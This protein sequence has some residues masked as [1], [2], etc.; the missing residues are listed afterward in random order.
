MVSLN[1]VTEPEPEAILGI[2]ATACRPVESGDH[3]FDRGG[4]AAVGGSDRRVEVCRDR[5]VR[6][7]LNNRVVVDRPER[8][9]LHSLP[10]QA[11]PR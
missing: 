10:H 8:Y 4:M 2:L 9:C 3:A 6:R 1:F 5:Q 7:R 11:K